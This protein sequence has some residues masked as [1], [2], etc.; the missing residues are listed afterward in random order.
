MGPA[1]IKFSVLYE[2]DRENIIK[3][4]VNKD[5]DE[6]D[7]LIMAARAAKATYPWSMIMQI[8][9]EGVVKEDE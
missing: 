2:N 1:T 7:G 3:V 5:Q 6:A 9:F 8:R 4:H